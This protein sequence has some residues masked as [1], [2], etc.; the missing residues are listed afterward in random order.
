MLS[1]SHAVKS[2]VGSVF[3]IGVGIYVS[4]SQVED[5]S[6]HL[7][8]VIDIECLVI[9]TFGLVDLSTIFAAQR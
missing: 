2:H 7:L 5:V 3:V 8:V 1:I 9:L 6:G 4:G